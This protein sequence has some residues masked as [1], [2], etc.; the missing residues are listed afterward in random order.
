M[1]KAGI[2]ELNTYITVISKVI[3]QYSKEEAFSNVLLDYM[4]ETLSIASII[5][6]FHGDQFLC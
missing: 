2:K 6:L 1:S 4:K 5:L 3:E